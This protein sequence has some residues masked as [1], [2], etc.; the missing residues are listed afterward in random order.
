MIVGWS[1][2]ASLL[3]S[4]L[5]CACADAQ[6][7]RHRDLEERFNRLEAAVVHTQACIQVLMNKHGVASPPQPR[8]SKLARV[9]GTADVVGGVCL[10][11]DLP[12]YATFKKTSTF[13][14]IVQAT[15]SWLLTVG[16]QGPLPLRVDTQA[17][18]LKSI[19][20]APIRDGARKQALNKLLKAHRM[21]VKS[22]EHLARTDERLNVGTNAVSEDKLLRIEDG[23]PS[24][25]KSSTVT[26]P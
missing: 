1:A 16:G 8:G 18:H 17:N 26:C 19:S 13:Q 10:Q 25:R 15:T 3:V 6:V 24:T 22:I 20:I 9:A 12:S 2:S 21:L 14:E 11:S 23:K 7:E 5:G 4:R